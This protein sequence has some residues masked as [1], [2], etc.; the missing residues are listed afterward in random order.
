MTLEQQLD[1]LCQKHMLESISVTR[2]TSGTCDGEYFCCVSV[3]SLDG[4]WDTTTQGTIG[5]QI[6]HCISV[7]AAKRTVGK[8]IAELV[9]AA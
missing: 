7:I 1:A 6:A 4:H 5:E 9:A 2:Q 3:R 8:S